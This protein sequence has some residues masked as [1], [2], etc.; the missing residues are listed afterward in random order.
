MIDKSRRL[1]NEFKGSIGVQ[2]GA[3][4]AVRVARF[5]LTQYAKTGGNI[6]QI[7]TKLPNGHKMYQMAVMNI[8][9]MAKEH[10]LFHYQNL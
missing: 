7:A 9:Q 4:V 10:N 2:D 1:A 8:F 5:F 6:Y 3:E